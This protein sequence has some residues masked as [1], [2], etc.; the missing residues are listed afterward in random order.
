MGGDLKQ[1]VKSIHVPVYRHYKILQTGTLT[2]LKIRTTRVR[3]QKTMFLSPE[4]E[5]CLSLT[6][7]KHPEMNLYNHV[8]LGNPPNPSLLVLRCIISF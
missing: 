8:T 6:M 3:M 2:G 5:A 7:V 1:G 4:T